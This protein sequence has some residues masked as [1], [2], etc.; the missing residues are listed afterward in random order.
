LKFKNK[1]QMKTI[2]EPAVRNELI[3]RVN[4]LTPNAP[5]VFGRMRPAQGLH[6]INAALQLYL[7]EITSPYHGN[8]F[9][10]GLFKLFTFSPLPIPRG[11]APT[12]P[13]LISEG[14]YDLEA[15]KA[16]FSSLLER[17]VAQPK[18]AQWP[19]HP[20]FGK[21]TGEQYGKLGYKHTDHHLQEFGV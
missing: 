6:H 21:M 4:K 14:T 1:I 17:V 15:E 8:N 13:P 9:K 20:L 10:A 19:I 3:E 2:F 12:A 5:Q 7:G 18:T 11:K 16:R